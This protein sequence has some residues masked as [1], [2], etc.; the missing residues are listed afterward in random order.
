ML[1]TVFRIQ[2]VDKVSIVFST[3]FVSISFA[4]TKT[5]MLLH[6]LHYIFM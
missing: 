6:N 5:L 4:E 3:E 1:H 2:S